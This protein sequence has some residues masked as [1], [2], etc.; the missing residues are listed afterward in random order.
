M[1]WLVLDRIQRDRDTRH[2]SHESRE[3][4]FF[5]LNELPEGLDSALVRALRK[6]VL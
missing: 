5:P 4:R 1:V 2:V 6:L 3:L